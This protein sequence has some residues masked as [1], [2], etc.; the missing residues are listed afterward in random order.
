MLDKSE[1]EKRSDEATKRQRTAQRMIM[2]ARKVRTEEKDIRLL[3]PL[4]SAKP[5][6][7]DIVLVSESPILEPNLSE[8]PRNI[9]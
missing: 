7:K 4:T 3:F 8:L 9:P 2:G 1:Y 5:M 6:L